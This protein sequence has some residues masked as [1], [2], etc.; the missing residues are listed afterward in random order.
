MVG[1]LSRS[2]TGASSRIAYKLQR[3]RIRSGSVIVG[4]RTFLLAV[5]LLLH[6]PV[7]ELEDVPVEVVDEVCEV[8]FVSFGGQTLPPD[9]LDLVPTRKPFRILSSCLGIKT[10]KSWG[11]FLLL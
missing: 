10:T 9:P 11:D 5:V 1:K 6:G 4:T 2:K 3:T 7:H 8:L